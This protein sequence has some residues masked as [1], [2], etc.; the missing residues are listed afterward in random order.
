MSD[1]REI[2]EQELS[3]ISSDESDYICK[4]AGQVPL[5]MLPAAAGGGL[6]G[7]AVIHSLFTPDREEIERKAK[8]NQM[9]NNLLSA[10]LGATAA[11]FGKPVVKG[12][13]TPKPESTVSFSS[14]EFDDIWKNRRKAL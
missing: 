12:M 13:L 5:Y 4:M 8:E 7:G 2:L 11:W 9:S 6:L 10:A 1:Y 14:D 3:N